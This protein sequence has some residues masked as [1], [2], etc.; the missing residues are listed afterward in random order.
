MLVAY[1]VFKF[2]D[3]W[4]V[5]AC[6][7]STFGNNS[8]YITTFYK[9]AG[10]WWSC[11]FFAFFMDWE[12]NFLQLYYWHCPKITNFLSLYSMQCFSCAISK[13]SCPKQAILAHLACLGSQPEPT[14]MLLIA[15]EHFI[16]YM[17]VYF[18]IIRNLGS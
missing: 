13:P 12:T 2:I 15:Q 17:L 10:K 8:D 5:N 7:A 18:L 6:F 11:S 14:W 9:M 1:K 4:K 3:V 16:H